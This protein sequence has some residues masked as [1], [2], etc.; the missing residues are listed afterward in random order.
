MAYNEKRLFLI[1]ELLSELPQ[2]KE[3]E[4]PKDTEEQKRLLRS[5]M[6]IR[7]PRSISSEFLKVQDEYLSGEVAEKGIVDGDTLAVSPVN[8]RLVLWRGDITT[9]KTEAIVNAANHALRGCF[10][11]CHSCVDNMIHSI[12]GIQLRL[13]CDKLMTEQ[14]YDEPTGKAK[15]TPA[16][17]L[18]C[19]YVLH[20]VGPI[21]SG[22]LTSTHCMQLADCYRSCLELASKNDLKSIAF[23][24]ISTGEFHFPQRKAAEIAVKTVTEYLQTDKQIERVIFNVFKQEDYDIYKKLLG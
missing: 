4:I 7:P 9:L 20:T 22:Q 16:F 3:A 17:N 23:C 1:K 2:Y 5:L 14:G 24:C 12:S 18:P 8:N 11:P 10:V 21:V 13:A 15:I 19:K 6:N